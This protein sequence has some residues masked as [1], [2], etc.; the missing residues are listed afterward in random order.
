M[1]FKKYAINNWFTCGNEL[2][3]L[4]VIRYVSAGVNREN[5]TDDN[6]FV[7]MIGVALCFRRC[8]NTAIAAIRLPK[9]VDIDPFLTFMFDDEFNDDDDDEWWRLL[10][11]FCGDWRKLLI[12][13]GFL[14]FVF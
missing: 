14:S 7:G 6:C 10:L 9:R 11:L 8:T 4:I 12:G 1:K 13:W 5:G 2:I 3:T